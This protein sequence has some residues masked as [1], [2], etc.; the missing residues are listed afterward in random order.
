MA[1]T[2]DTYIMTAKAGSAEFGVRLGAHS[3]IKSI[4]SAAPC[5]LLTKHLCWHRTSGAGERTGVPTTANLTYSIRA[6]NGTTLPAKTVYI[7]QRADASVSIEVRAIGRMIDN[8][9]IA[10]IIGGLL[11]IV[12]TATS[13]SGA[14]ISEKVFVSGIVNDVEQAESGF[15][16]YASGLTEP[17]PV[18]RIELSNIL[19]IKSTSSGKRTI[20]A[21]LS[22]DIQAGDIV[23]HSS[24]A[25]LKAGTIYMSIERGYKVLEISEEI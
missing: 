7:R 6:D 17:R 21:P 10:D 19:Y 12:A 16:V 2:A 14:I 18:Q 20:S 15:S 25:D 24:M 13:S 9:D 22:W 4:G 8:P 5:V 3:T 1:E 23:A 11:S